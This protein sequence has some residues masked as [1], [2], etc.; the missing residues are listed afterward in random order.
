ME[1]TNV[2]RRLE[3]KK[4]SYVAHT[5]DSS[6]AVSGE[7]VANILNQDP[8]R[9]FK[10]LVT[11][12]KSKTNYVFVIPVLK[13]LDLKKAAKE[14]HEKSIDMLK[15]KEL[16]PLTGY[17]HGGCSPIGMKK[18]FKTVIHFTAED[19]DTIFFSGGKLGYQVEVN[20]KDIKKIIPFE[21][22][23]VIVEDK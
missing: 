1:K 22:A 16:L 15:S 5:Y 18:Q 2:M 6:V 7:E 14:V 21:Y 9:V 10:T 20:P 19:F 4:I 13:E 12:S 11:T 3:Q 8:K 17:I 23:D